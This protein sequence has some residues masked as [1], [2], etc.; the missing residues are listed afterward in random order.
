MVVGW[1]VLVGGEGRSGRKKQW[2]EAEVK[3]TKKGEA[4]RQEKSETDRLKILHA[5]THT[6][7]LA[8]ICD[9][10]HG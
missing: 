2:K 6:Q 8:V 10:A 9:L 7:E 5:H 4:Q 3:K 1:M